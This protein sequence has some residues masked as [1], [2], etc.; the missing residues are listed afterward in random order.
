MKQIE[1]TQDKYALVDDEDFEFLNQWKWYAKKQGNKR[2]AARNS[3]KINGKQ[4]TILMSRLIMECPPDKEVDHIDRNPLNNQRYNLRICTHQENTQ[5]S[6]KEARNTT[7]FKGVSW[8]RNCYEV[9]IRAEGR[10]VYIGR[11]SDKKIAAKMYN[12]AAIKHHG[13][14]ALLNKI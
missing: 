9:Y 12:D 6:A 3:K 5:N 10:Q 8:H 11:S 1:L 7:G 14:F 13:K 4:K 2:I